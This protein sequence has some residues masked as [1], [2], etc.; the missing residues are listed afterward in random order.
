MGSFRSEP[1]NFRN[2][3][4]ALHRSN[5]HQGPSNKPEQG[6]IL[7]R[8]L[9]IAA[10]NELVRE[11]PTAMVKKLGPF[12]RRVLFNGDEYIYRPDD[13]ID[14]VYFPETAVFSELEILEDGRT[15]EVSMTGREGSIGLSAV[16]HSA[17]AGSWIQACAPGTA[18]RVMAEP[19]G[20]F[21][22]HNDHV[23]SAFHRFMDSHVR[24]ISHKAACGAHHSVRERFSTW[25]L[26][27]QDRCH[28]SRLKLTQEQCARALGVYRPSVTCIAQDLRK[29]GSIDYVRGYIIIRDREN[30][31][32]QCCECYFDFSIP[33]VT[34]RN[35]QAFPIRD[36]QCAV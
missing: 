3:G 6:H 4:N 27:L 23:M 17:T 32:K 8:P 31:R 5:G 16:Y 1:G 34:K 36:V 13:E 10:V 20:R 18:I 30:L 19:L 26:M 21:T 7:T 33:A 22:K 9:G 28:H 2:D 29:E 35:V 11:M 25:L 24:Q 15:I 12:A 14:W